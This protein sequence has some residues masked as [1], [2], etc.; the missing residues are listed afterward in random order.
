MA[1]AGA[2]ANFTVSSLAK[3]LSF[4]MPPRAISCTWSDLQAAAEAISIQP[5]HS[6]LMLGDFRQQPY[7]VSSGKACCI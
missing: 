1:S 2:F 6:L 4:S 3:A 7:I 5:D